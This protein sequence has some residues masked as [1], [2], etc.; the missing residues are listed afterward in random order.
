LVA[1]GYVAGVLSLSAVANLC[2]LAGVNTRPANVRNFARRELDCYCLCLMF[3]VAFVRH[4]YSV[5]PVN[6]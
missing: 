2:E 4:E 1:H 5:A 3:T 6:S